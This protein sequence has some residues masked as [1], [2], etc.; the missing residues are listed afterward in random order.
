M[1][2]YTWLFIYQC[3]SALNSTCWD[4]FDASGISA[5][6]KIEV[7]QGWACA[8]CFWKN[9]LVIMWI[10]SVLFCFL[11]QIIKANDFITRS[12]LPTERCVRGTNGC[13]SVKLVSFIITSVLCCC[14]TD[15]C[16]GVS[17]L[18]GQPLTL[19]ATAIVLIQLVCRWI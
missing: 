5:A 4:P 9:S 2:H 6:E 8:V 12:T 16:N 17:M 19:L 7:P 10:L 3:T 15:L 11:I 1:K 18:R 13:H 14:T